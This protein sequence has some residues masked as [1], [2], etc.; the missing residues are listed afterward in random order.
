MTEEEAST[1]ANGW[2]VET[3]E[4]H[5]AHALDRSVWNLISYYRQSQGKPAKSICTRLYEA[6]P[7]NGCRPRDL[8]PW[9]VHEKKQETP[10]IRAWRRHYWDTI[11]RPML[12][13]LLFMTKLKNTTVRVKNM[14]HTTE[15]RDTNI[16][17]LENNVPYWDVHFR[18]GL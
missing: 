18:L 1:D 6:F 5:A 15:E 2:P 11:L 10:Q 16:Q 8:A 4:S 3:L 12:T 14:E 9:T 7:E 17:N 13:D